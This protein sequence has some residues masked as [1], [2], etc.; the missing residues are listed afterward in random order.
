MADSA[1]AQFDKAAEAKSRTV[2]FIRGLQQPRFGIGVRSA[3]GPYVG[4]GV[5]SPRSFIVCP[6]FLTL[7][8][9]LSNLLGG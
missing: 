3:F 9:F 4:R 7:G 8:G 6:L 1:S 5:L 2:K